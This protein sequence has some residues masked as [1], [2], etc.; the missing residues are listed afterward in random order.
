M[1]KNFHVM[2]KSFRQKYYLYSSQRLVYICIPH[3]RLAI[4]LGLS[5][6]ITSRPLI[7]EISSGVRTASSACRPG[8]RIPRPAHCRAWWD[9]G[10]ATGRL[11]LASKMARMVVCGLCDP[12]TFARRSLM[13]ASSQTACTCC[14]AGAHCVDGGICRNERPVQS[15]DF[16]G[17]KHPVRGITPLG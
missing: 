16:S 15:L 6:R 1:C 12:K 13:P 11:G 2:G 17:N 8:T 3:R 9:F 5:T 4:V 10:A 7:C 14:A